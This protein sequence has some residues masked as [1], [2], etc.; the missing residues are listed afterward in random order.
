MVKRSFLLNTRTSH[1]VNLTWDPKENIFPKSVLF[2]KSYFKES[3]CKGTHSHANVSCSVQFS[4]QLDHSPKTFR[5]WEIFCKS[6]LVW[7]I[8]T[9]IPTHVNLATN[10][11]TDMGRLIDFTLI[12][13]LRNTTKPPVFYCRYVKIILTCSY[14]TLSQKLKNSSRN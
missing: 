7:F 14:R 8:L 4:R 9:V 5:G 3:S 2:P 11:K 1:T 12:T 13:P 10:I 6:L